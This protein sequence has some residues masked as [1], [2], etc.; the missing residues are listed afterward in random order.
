MDFSDITGSVTN[1][2]ENYGW[3]FLLSTVVGF[4]LYNVHLKERIKEYMKWKSEQEYSA[5][6]HKDPDLLE[7]RLNAQQAYADKLQEKYNR[8]AAEHKKNVEEKEAQK[9]EN[10]LNKLQGKGGAKLG[11]SSKPDYNP[12]MGAGTSGGYRPPKKSCCKKGGGCG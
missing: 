5:K 3:Y 8:E 4:Y 11:S 9:R 1:F 2:V 12:L 6:Y 10:L 7:R